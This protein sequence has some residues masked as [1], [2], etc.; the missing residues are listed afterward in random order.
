MQNQNKTSQGKTLIDLTSRTMFIFS[1]LLSWIKTDV[2][3][4]KHKLDEAKAGIKIATRRI[5][6]LRY[7]DDIPSY[8]KVKKN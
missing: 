6:N 3:C 4:V 2:G 1:W 7:E 5:N 8:Q